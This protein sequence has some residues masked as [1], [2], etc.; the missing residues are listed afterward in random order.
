MEAVDHALGAAPT[1]GPSLVSLAPFSPCCSPSPRR[2]SSNF[3]QPSRPVSASRR[4]SWLS[5]QGRLIGVAEATSARTIGPGLE[6]DEAVSWEL[7][8]PMHRLLLVAVAAVAS[9]DSNK[10]RQIF[11][12]RQSVE[13]RDQVLSSM[14]QK[15]DDLCEQMNSMKDRSETVADK[16]FPE[17]DGRYSETGKTKLCNCEHLISNFKRDAIDKE[18]GGD[19][20]FKLH[21]SNMN[22]AEQEERRMSDLSDWC[23]S[24]TSAADIQLNA[25]AVEQDIYNLQKACEEKDATIKELAAI[26][27][28]SNV[29]GSKRIA[30]LED[31]I[32]R[33][34]TIITR[35]KKDMM[36][37]EQKLMHLT[38]L[39]RPSFSPSNSNNMPLPA[40][41]TN[42][43]YDM[44]S[45]TSPS[46]SDSDCP[47]DRQNS[48]EH[49]SK[50]LDTHEDQNIPH[51]NDIAEGKSQKLSSTKVPISLSRSNGYPKQRS[52]SPLKEN[53][54]NERADS[55]MVYRPRQLVSASAY[56]TR[57]RKH[58]PPGSKDTA[59]H[60]RWV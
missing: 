53:S 1:P 58:I 17:Y 8:S 11:H 43:L 6:P 51:Q 2:L 27:Q 47:I 16:L 12:L 28:A 24:V 48:R 40:M 36:I 4:L 19:E 29:A 49:L 38:R 23:S 41:A 18:S 3:C 30:D 56:S 14:Q 59:A 7:F 60:K 25:L 13:L 46:S 31:I 44:D 32:R 34:N 22:V 10:N 33:K 20:D 42:L 37:L 50:H 52:V 9:A 26:A 5:L 55:S 15:L 45:S 54:M 39:R 35:L 57:N 21:H